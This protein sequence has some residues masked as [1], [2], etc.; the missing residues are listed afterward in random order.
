MCLTNQKL[1]KVLKTVALR[2]KG[3]IAV[4]LILSVLKFVAFLGNSLK[5]NV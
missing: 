3:N 5:Q 2:L 4:F 1:V